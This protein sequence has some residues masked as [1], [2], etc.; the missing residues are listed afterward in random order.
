MNEE[1]AIQFKDFYH[2]ELKSLDQAVE[3]LVNFLRSRGIP[4]K[5]IDTDSEDF[6]VM[7]QFMFPLNIKRQDPCFFGD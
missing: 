5:W 2:D 1:Y 6:K 4:N 7:K 3:A